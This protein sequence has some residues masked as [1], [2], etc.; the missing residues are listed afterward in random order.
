MLI[1][2]RAIVLNRQPYNDSF[3][4]ANFLTE[5]AGFVAY[6]IPLGNRGKGSGERLRRLTTPLNELQIVAEH[7]EKRSLQRICEAIPAPLRLNLMTDPQKRAIAFFL[8]EMLCGLFRNSRI[9]YP[10]YDYI[11]RSLGTLDGTKRGI[12]NF[13]L[14]FLFGLLDYCGIAPPPQAFQGHMGEWFNLSEVSFTRQLGNGISIAPD[15]ARFLGT[16]CRINYANMQAF[17]FNVKERRRIL[18]LLIAFYRI[19]F[20]PIGELKS[21]DVLSELSS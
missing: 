7:R 2:T 19:H 14:A 6:R 18:E 11:S 20:A 4:I 12:E 8:A 5:E 16:F 10:L 13:H 3:A 9:E 21:I 1:T 17:R 15:E